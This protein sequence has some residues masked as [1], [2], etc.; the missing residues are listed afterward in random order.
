MGADVTTGRVI[1]GSL[2]E[3]AAVSWDCSSTGHGDPGTAE[4]TGWAVRLALPLLGKSRHKDRVAGDERQHPATFRAAAGHGH[5]HLDESGQVELI[6]PET[7]GLERAV[8]SGPDKVVIRLLR[9][10]SRFFTCGLPGTQNGPHRLGTLHQF[11]R[12]EIGF[13]WKNIAR[14]RGFF[15]LRLWRHESPGPGTPGLEEFTSR[16]LPQ[17]RIGWELRGGR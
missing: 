16:V 4:L 13:R 6:A 15:S 9:Q 12:S 5:N 10:T 3:V 8:E 17:A 11:L 1:P 7:A 2:D 14:F